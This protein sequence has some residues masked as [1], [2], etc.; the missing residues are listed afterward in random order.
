VGPR[1]S[2]TGDRRDLAGAWKAIDELRRAVDEMRI[3]DEVAE[4]V[5]VEIEEHR[6]I[7]LTF[8][9]KVAAVAVALVTVGTFALSVYTVLSR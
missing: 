4:R 3:A 6:M 8:V 5:K 7:G 9:T 2:W 1:E